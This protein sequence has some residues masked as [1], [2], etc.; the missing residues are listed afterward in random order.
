MAIRTT[1]T[2]VYNSLSAL[3]NANL[4]LSH[5]DNP[6]YQESNV[7]GDVAELFQGILDADSTRFLDPDGSVITFSRKSIEREHGTG[8]GGEIDS[9]GRFEISGAGDSE[10]KMS[11]PLEVYKN[12]VLSPIAGGAL[13]LIANVSGSNRSRYA[14]KAWGGA[15][16]LACLNGMMTSLAIAKESKKQ[17]SNL[18][19]RGV[20]MAMLQ[21]LA[22]TFHGFGL[23][24]EAMQNR[25]VNRQELADFLISARQLKVASFQNCGGVLDLF[26]ETDS[27]WFSDDNRKP[28]VW[29]LFNA[30]TR[31]AES[32]NSSDV[33]QKMIQGIYW[34]LA[35]V[36][37]FDLP[38]HC[39]YSATYNSLAVDGRTPTAP[40]EVAD[41][42][43]T[44]IDVE[45][46]AV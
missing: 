21:Q 23:D 16:V 35:H 41:P 7:I 34:P 9:S 45:S 6:V 3:Q 31:Q 25:S 39:S 29:R 10:Y 32:Q 1:G 8:D 19:I 33:R 27:P 40:P 20:I 42:R 38:E 22:N 5:P 4:T 37:L 13:S 43:Q 44:V 30:F 14:L 36:G 12:D 2:K 17:T 18:D 28:T 11:F 26:N 46:I 24:V 15:D